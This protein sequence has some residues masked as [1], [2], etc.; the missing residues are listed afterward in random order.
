MD[1]SS[2][3]FVS[4]AARII[5]VAP[6]TLRSWEKTGR[7]VPARIAGVRIYDRAEVERVAA[8]RKASIVSRG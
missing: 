7:L 5:G 2:S 6:H 8:E 3:I 1:N 4:E